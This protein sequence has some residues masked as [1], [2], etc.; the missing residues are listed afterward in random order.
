MK[1]FLTIAVVLL[2]AVSAG[3]QTF[4][5]ALT[6]SENNYTGSARS[7]ALG[8][9]VTS[10]GGDLGTVCINPAGSAV[11]GFSQVAVTPGL[12]ISSVNSV[13]SG[14]G[15]E[16]TGRNVGY[17]R[18]T[19]PNVGASFRFVTGNRSGVKSFTFGLIAT[20]TNNFTSNAVGGGLNSLTSKFAELATGAEKLM[21]K[22][23]TVDQMA[24][25]N[26]YNNYYDYWDVIVGYQS[27][28]VNHYNSGTGEGYIGADETLKSD[29]SSHYIPGELRQNSSVMKY[30]NKTDVLVNFGFNVNDKVYFG[31]NIGVPSISYAQSEV[32]S[33]KPEDMTLFPV[34]F[35]STAMGMPGTVKTYYTGGTFTYSYSATAAGVYGK[36]GIIA[37]PVENLRIGAAIKTPTFFTFAERWMDSGSVTYENGNYNGSARSP[38]AENRYCLR[39][40]YEANFGISYVFGRRA[41]LSVD[42]EL[43]DYAAAKFSEVN[44]ESWASDYYSSVNEEIRKYAG[45]SHSLRAGAEINVTDFLSLRGGF[46]L[47]TCPEKDENG[48]YFKDLTLSYSAGIGYSSAGPFFADLG[49]KYTKYPPYVYYPY[50]DYGGMSSPG[51]TTTRNLINFALTLG[52][53]F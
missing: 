43:T 49:F 38:Q 24:G 35:E 42:Y 45:L 7:M 37:L 5:D 23:V 44:V 39:T 26:I 53:R 40:A 32:F 30:G 51:V 14:N 1:R 22:G 21:N 16:G 47:N 13:F 46:N 9:A 33:E 10:V 48:A 29:Y 52:W 41:L 6:F 27:G 15:V 31:F 18:F 2:M 19:L 25:Q 28:L 4:Y 36:F 12:S 50:Y 3:A 11:S 34:N 20:S 8:N 17:T